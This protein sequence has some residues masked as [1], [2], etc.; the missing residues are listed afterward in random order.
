[1]SRLLRN[2]KLWA[3]VVGLALVAA[4][5]FGQAAL[6]REAAAQ[7]DGLVWG[8]IFEVDPLWPNPLPNNWVIGAAI[9]VSV[10]D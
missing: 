3:G 7:A 1:M 8:P 6:E 2:R 5:G 4:L 9:G 10:D